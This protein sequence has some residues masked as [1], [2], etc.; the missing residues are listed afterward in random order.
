[1]GLRQIAE[2]DL[3]F[4]L[5]DE[6]A[7]FA[8]PISVTDPAGT[9]AN[10]LGFS[11]DISQAIDPDT[12]IF[13]SGRTASATLRISSLSDAGLSLP[14]SIADDSS[15]PWIIV[16]DDINGN[17][18]TFKVIEGNPDRALGVVVCLLELYTL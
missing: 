6:V 12:G 3:E 16:F 11:N 18:Y 7:G 9:T 5:E 13:V 15:K 17:S 4:I 10:F 2:A 8:F 14:I 1:M